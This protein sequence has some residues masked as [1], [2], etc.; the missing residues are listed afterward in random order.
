MQRKSH[1]FHGKKKKVV[2]EWLLKAGNAKD[3]RRALALKWL[4]EGCYSSY[5]YNVEACNDGSWIYLRR[6]TF[7]NKGFDFQVNLQGF[8]KYRR[9]RL[10]VTRDM[11]SHP[12]VIRD[13]QKK[14]KKYPRLTKDL[15]RAICAVYDCVEVPLVLKKFPKLK[16][17]QTA[18]AGLP[19]DKTLRII[20]W[21]FIEQDLTY[22]LGTGRN[23]FMAGIES[24]VFGIKTK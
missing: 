16:K 24:K 23:M 1:A 6:P 19:I 17:L 4:K 5:R 10:G 8:G 11:P 2:I 13:L 14:K 9:K 7:K 15:F 18:A 20:K 12:A 3:Q 22:W 21:L